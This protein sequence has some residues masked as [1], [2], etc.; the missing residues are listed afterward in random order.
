MN[1][2]KIRVQI[3]VLKNKTGRTALLSNAFFLLTS[4]KPSNAAEQNANISHIK[5]KKCRGEILLLKILILYVF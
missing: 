3:T 2:I 1:G 5:E 4:Y